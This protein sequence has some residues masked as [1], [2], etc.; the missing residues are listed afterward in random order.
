MEAESS[1]ENEESGEEIVLKQK[2][3]EIVNMICLN[4][5]AMQILHL[6]RLFKEVESGVDDAK[7]SS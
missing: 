2:H 5:A 1:P 3:R 4:I 7:P 6:Q